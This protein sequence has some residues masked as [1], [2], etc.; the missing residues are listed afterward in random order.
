MFNLPNIQQSYEEVLFEEYG[1]ASL[2]RSTGPQFSAALIDP[3]RDCC[4]GNHRCFNH[5][6]IDSGYSFTHIV[7][8]I[9][10]EAVLKGTKR[11]SLGGKVLTNFLKETVSFRYYNMMEETYLMNDIKEA[12]CYVSQDFKSELRLAKSGYSVAQRYVLPDFTVNRHGR[13]ILDV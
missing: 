11:M 7:P 3:R 13:V 1:V 2:L 4:I 8:F 5:S 9:N 6:V 10:G 12:L